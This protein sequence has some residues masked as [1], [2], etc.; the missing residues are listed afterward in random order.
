MGRRGNWQRD[1]AISD[2]VASV[3]RCRSTFESAFVVVAYM[4]LVDAG[5]LAAAVKQVKYF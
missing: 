4:E 3:W 5:I 1:L 2:S